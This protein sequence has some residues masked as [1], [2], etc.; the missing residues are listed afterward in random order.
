MWKSVMFCSHAMQVSRTSCDI[1]SLLNSLCVLQD[2]AYA[3]EECG[4]SNTVYGMV[5]NTDKRYATIPS[6]SG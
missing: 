4:V 1:L 3:K 5:R 6:G 2:I